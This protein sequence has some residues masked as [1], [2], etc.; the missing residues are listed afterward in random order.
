MTC[1]AG[2]KMETYSNCEHI[3]PYNSTFNSLKLRP[4]DTVYHQWSLVQVIAWCLAFHT[5]NTMYADALAHSAP[6]HQHAWYWP[7]FQ[8]ISSLSRRIK[9]L[10]NKHQL[11][12]WTILSQ[13]WRH[14]QNNNHFIH[15]SPIQLEQRSLQLG[16]LHHWIQHWVAS[17]LV[18]SQ[19]CN[20]PI[21]HLYGRAQNNSC[22][23]DIQLLFKTT[24]SIKPFNETDSKLFEAVNQRTMLEYQQ[25]TPVTFDPESTKLLD[26]PD[27][28]HRWKSRLS[29]HFGGKSTG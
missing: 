17:M 6:G 3:H 25:N 12:I 16:C 8:E 7:S 5:I 9:V 28:T 14:Q 24:N 18:L 2:Y 26:T 1:M 27:Q 29:E 20:P 11:I 4:G 19:V 22:K 10:Q 13:T 15:I 21:S 23:F